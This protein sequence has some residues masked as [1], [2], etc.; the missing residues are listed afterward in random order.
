[1][2]QDQPAA[3]VRLGEQCSAFQCVAGGGGKIGG[4]EQCSGLSH[5]HSSAG[6]RRAIFKHPV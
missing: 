5:G 2:R 6:Q 1:M 3:G 4:G